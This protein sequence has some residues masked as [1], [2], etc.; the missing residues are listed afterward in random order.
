MVVSEGVPKTVQLVF[1][2]LWVEETLPCE[3][4]CKTYTFTRGFYMG[5]TAKEGERR[6]P[7]RGLEERR[8]AVV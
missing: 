4:P 1:R 2:F 5:K 6:R 8:E 7:S 3:G